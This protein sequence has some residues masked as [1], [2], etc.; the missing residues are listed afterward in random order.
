MQ[1]GVAICKDLDYPDYINKYGKSRINFIVV[2]A[3]DFVINDWLHS[4]M[5]ILRGVENGFSM[6]RTAR[7]G[8]L[9][10]SD[11]YGRVTYE[12]NG[13]NGQQSYLSGKVSVEHK[14]TLYSRFGNWFGIVDLIA[15]M[16]LIFL[17]IIER[18]KHITSANKSILC[19][20]F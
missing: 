8:R 2:P 9:T 12:T 7:Q 16:C 3:W 10:I 20:F 13:S 11:C 15:A 4:R 17:I 19:T 1:A 5:T 6:I 18:K 14:N